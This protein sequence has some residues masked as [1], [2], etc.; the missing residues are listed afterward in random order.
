MLSVV[1]LV[2]CGC[3]VLMLSRLVWNCISR[4]FVFVLLFICSLLM[5]MFELV[6][7][8][9]SMLSDWYVIV[10]SVVC[11]RCV[12]FVLCVMLNIELCVCVF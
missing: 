11:V 1:V 5:L 6:F 10:L 2:I 4:L 9:V 3:I 7:I 12:V 8:V